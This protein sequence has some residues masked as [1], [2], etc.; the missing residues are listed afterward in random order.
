V[1]SATAATT[2]G[3]GVPMILES[4]T[5]SCIAKQVLTAEIVRV[6]EL[7]DE[8][9][10]KPVAGSMNGPTGVQARVSRKLAAGFDSICAAGPR[11]RLSL[12]ETEADIAIGRDEFKSKIPWL[13]SHDGVRPLHSF[14]DPAGDGGVDGVAILHSA[15]LI[16]CACENS[17]VKCTLSYFCQHL[18][19][20]MFFNTKAFD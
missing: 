4:S 10:A 18:I 3:N 8:E 19:I 7:A 15:G 14:G 20:K 5:H 6:G 1:C 2:L 11:P 17:E 16:A 9:L 12:S 13:G